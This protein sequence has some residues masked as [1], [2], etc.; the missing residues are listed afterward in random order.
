MTAAAGVNTGFM[1]T[2]LTS[3]VQG[4]HGRGSGIPNCDVTN[5]NFLELLVVNSPAAP[6]EP[7]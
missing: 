5:F 1:G 6:H 2:V 4:S 3:L 7:I